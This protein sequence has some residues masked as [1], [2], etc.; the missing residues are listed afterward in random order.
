MGDLYFQSNGST[1]HYKARLVAKRYKQESGIGYKETSVKV[2]KMVTIH[3]LISM[4][5]ARHQPL[6]QMDVKNAS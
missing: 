5:A 6:Y 1:E 3:T 4:T 2:V